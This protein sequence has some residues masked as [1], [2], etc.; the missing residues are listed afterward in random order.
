MT[1]SRVLA[2]RLMPGEGVLWEA[3]R[4]AMANV[5]LVLCAHVAVPIPGNPVPFTLQTFGVLMIAV[6]LGARRAAVVTMMYLV[7]G[8]MGLPVFQPFGLPGAAR[9]I[10]PT[11]GYLWA[12]PLAAY[13]TG[14][15]TERLNWSARTWRGMAMLAA[16]VVGG[17]ILILSGGWAW[18]AAI[19]HMQANGA[20]GVLGWARAFSLGV[21][22]FLLDAVLKTGLVIAAAR[23]M[24][25]ARPA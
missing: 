7:E 21:V 6:M 17:H 5:L 10:G 19:P 25:R 22:P 20:I 1:H 9:L 3:A 23:S 4:L 16:A 18:L 8:A 12:Y 14:W 13:A 24:N 15:I 2:E 11:A